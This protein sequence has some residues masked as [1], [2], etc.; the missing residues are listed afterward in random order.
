M[1]NPFQIVRIAEECV[2]GAKVLATGADASATLFADA[3]S[4]VSKLLVD[5]SHVQAKDFLLDLRG[6]MSPA[7]A[8]MIDSAL[9]TQDGVIVKGL[10]DFYKLPTAEK[11][12]LTDG[13]WEMLQKA[14]SQGDVLSLGKARETLEQFP[15][16][17]QLALRTFNRL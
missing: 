3:T 10:A 16:Y 7:G 6:K 4:S 14:L 9:Q 15:T 12:I 17:V 13:D 1:V 8:K 5:P 11:D 2:D